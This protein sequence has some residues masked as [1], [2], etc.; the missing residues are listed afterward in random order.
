MMRGPKGVSGRRRELQELRGLPDDEGP[1]H[2][3]PGV[4][5]ILEPSS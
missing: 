2:E 4:C 1:K 3:R 5:L